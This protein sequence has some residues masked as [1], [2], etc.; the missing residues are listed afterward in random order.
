MPFP[1]YVALR[2]GTYYVRRPLPLDVQPAFGGRREIWRS[3]RTTVRR[4]AEARSHGVLADIEREI[5]AKRRE[6]GAADEEQ[7]FLAS[8]PFD[9]P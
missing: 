8:D 7:A 9:L 1:K 5:A 2:E 3:L 4:E 6:L